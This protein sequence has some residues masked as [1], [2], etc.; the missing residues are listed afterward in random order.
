MARNPYRTRRNQRF[1]GYTNVLALTCHI[2]CI[3]HP[4]Q[5]QEDI[6]ERFLRITG[7]CSHSPVGRYSGAMTYR[8]HNESNTEP[9]VEVTDL[10]E[11]TL[12]YEGETI[13][14]TR[15]FRPGYDYDYTNS[16]SGETS[17][18]HSDAWEVWE[19]AI[20]GRRFQ[21]LTSDKNAQDAIARAKRAIDR[22]NADE[23]VYPSLQSYVGRVEVE[24]GPAIKDEAGKWHKE[25]ISTNLTP[26]GQVKVGD[27]V[28]TYT[29]GYWRRVVVSKIGRKNIEVAYVTSVGGQI[30]RKS[31]AQDSVYKEVVA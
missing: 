16:Y 30:T 24:L 7:I 10:P 5:A 3:E 26:A 27:H 11:S 20:D 1:S 22:C 29:R 18:L 14:I 13:T 8:Y 6:P 15:R 4:R 25:V 31:V 28:V 19:A 2:V 21:G 23:A 17:T 9:S 12:T